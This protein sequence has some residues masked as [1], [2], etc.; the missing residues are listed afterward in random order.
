MKNYIKN[1]TVTI[2][3]SCKRK[4]MKNYVEHSENKNIFIIH[5]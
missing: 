3:F 5:A 2:Y 4:M 1:Y